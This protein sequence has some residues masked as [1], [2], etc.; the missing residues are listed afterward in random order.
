M[1][2]KIKHLGFV[3]QKQSR[4]HLSSV[5]GTPKRQSLSKINSMSTPVASDRIAELDGIRGLAILMVLSLHICKRAEY[6]TDNELFLRLSS[7]TRL[8]WAGVDIFFV[9]SGFLITGILL[10]TLHR[11]NY[12]KNF[13]ARRILRIFP[14]YYLLVGGLLI[15][16]PVLD[17]KSGPDAP[18]TWPYF[19]LYQ[20]NWLSVFDK[21]P[22]TFLIPTW[23]LAIE[24]QFYLLWP[25]VV[26]FL[27]RRALAITSAGIVIFSLLFRIVLI[28]FR[29]PLLGIISLPNL[30]YYG[31][32]TR[33][34]GLA[35][36]ALLAIAF[37]SSNDWKK[38]LAPWAWP[39]LLISF[40][41]FLASAQAGMSTPVSTNFPLSIFGYTLL[42]LI[43]G[44][45]IVL[46]A[47]GPAESWPR[48][49]F[50]HPILAFFGNYSY[51]MYLI[52]MPLVSILLEMMWRTGRRNL[53]M[54]LA[55]LALSFTGTVLLSVL[56]WHLFEKHL[57]KLKHYF[58]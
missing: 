5:S 47:T 37:E 38:R 42:A 19:L 29:T 50:R 12:F 1:G 39:V 41:L 7:L 13:Y 34:E 21:I 35:L 40:G 58:E 48:R 15:F 36:G 54:A 27:K 23:S 3:Q 25:A 20:Q 24:E 17:P 46:V 51:A 2:A 43:A 30:F 55:F 32:V 45:L 22:S 11:P 26:F 28:Q 10:R 14:L 6:F 57:L 53:L 31:S 18:Q 56:S 9:L 49:I 33:F 52:H 4:N 8:G 44:A 16:L